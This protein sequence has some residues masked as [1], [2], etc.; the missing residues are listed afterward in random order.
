MPN[1]HDE[2]IKF[3]QDDLNFN[4]QLDPKMQKM[5]FSR[6]HDP[7]LTPNH[8]HYQPDNNYDFNNSPMLDQ[9]KRT[10]DLDDIENFGTDLKRKKLAYESMADEK[11]ANKIK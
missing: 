7:E 3:S 11:A 10:P 9:M 2:L 1:G 5:S 4:Y 6:I 8:L